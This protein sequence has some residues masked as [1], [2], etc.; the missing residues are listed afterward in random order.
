M[1][2]SDNISNIIALFDTSK[3]E[4]CT[5]PGEQDSMC[6][7]DEDAIIYLAVSNDK[8]LY[9]SDKVFYS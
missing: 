6:T 4:K 9:Y 2:A 8:V 3:A 1:I 5:I 7:L